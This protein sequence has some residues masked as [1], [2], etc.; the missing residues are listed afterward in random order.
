M[1]LLRKNSKMIILA[2][3]LGGAFYVYTTFFGGDVVVEQDASAEQVGSE[4][5]ALKNS[6]ESVNLDQSLFSYSTYKSLID[7]STPLP[8]QTPGRLNPFNLIGTD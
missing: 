4:I 3:V 8:Q 5:L 7:F 6:L 2:L 1:E